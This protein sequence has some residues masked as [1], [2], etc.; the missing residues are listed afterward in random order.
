MIISAIA[1]WAGSC[2]PLHGNKLA[3]CGAVPV[4]M[5]IAILTD[6]S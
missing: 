1:Q 3:T 2:V 4:N 5:I 6:W